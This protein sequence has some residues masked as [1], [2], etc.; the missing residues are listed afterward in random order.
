MKTIAQVWS[1]PNILPGYDFTVN[2]T[3]GIDKMGKITGCVN[4]RAKTQ[5]DADTL[6]N[7]INTYWVENKAFPP[8]G[9]FPQMIG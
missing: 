8:I 2:V 1:T 4:H 6:A 5:D 3:T 9:M 7:N